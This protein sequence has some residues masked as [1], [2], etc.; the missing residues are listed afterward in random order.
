[1][2]FADRPFIPDS[3]TSTNDLSSLKKCINAAKNCEG[4]QFLLQPHLIFHP[5]IGLRIGEMVKEVRYPRCFK[6]RLIS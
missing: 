3:N 6:C 1:M 2:Q 4:S 5:Y